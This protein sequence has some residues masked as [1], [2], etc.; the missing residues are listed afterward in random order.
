MKCITSNK[1]KALLII[2]LALIL[3]LSA[4]LG[5][6]QYTIPDEVSYFSGKNIPT[7]LFA[8]A[9]IKDAHPCSTGNAQNLF[10]TGQY[11][12]EYR[13]FGFLPVKSVNLTAYKE[14]K[15]YPGGMPFGV[16]FFT[17]GVLIVGFCDVD[18]ENG[19]VNPAYAAGLRLKD[20]VTHVG[21]KALSGAVE[22][23]ELVE[24]SGG[25]PLEIQYSRNGEQHTTTI[26]PVKSQ[27]DGKYKTGIWVRDSGA[28]IGTVSFIV[29]ET[30]YF[31]GLGHGICDT[32]TG[33]LLPIDR[34]TVVDVTISG[35]TKGVSGTPGEIKGFF[36]AGKT[37]SLLG[38]NECGVFGVFAGIPETVPTEPLPIALKQDVKEGDAYIY[39]TLDN[40]EITKYNIR[41]TDI[42]RN[43]EGGKCFTVKIT[44]PALLE[45]TGGIIQGMSGSPIIQGGK[46]VGAVTHVCVN[47]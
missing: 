35:I 17:S 38:N 8:D 23:T 19:Q 26:T 46:L 29:P 41:I 45:K 18:T 20:M 11:E 12:A 32:D 5:V 42:N 14:L 47:Q 36:N 43:A 28:G 9:E 4:V 27:S 6:Y 44:D 15:L 3:F 31:A 7:Y 25:A 30:N 40:N 10:C 21:G 16:K 34:G 24:S 39:C 13:L 1:R 37:G 33:K 2:P 22:L